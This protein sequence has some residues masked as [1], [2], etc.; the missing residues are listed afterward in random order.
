M[1][2]EVQRK[3][4]EKQRKLERIK[5]TRLKLEW[6]ATRRIWKGEWPIELF[7]EYEFARD[8][9]ELS[10]IRSHQAFDICRT[11]NECNE[12]KVVRDGKVTPLSSIIDG[13]GIQSLPFK[14]RH[15]LV[16]IFDKNR[17]LVVKRIPVTKK[18]E[19][20]RRQF[21]L[22]NNLL[23]WYIE[24][25]RE[26]VCESV[27]PKTIKYGCHRE[28]MRKPRL[29][30]DSCNGN[31]YPNAPDHFPEDLTWEVGPNGEVIKTIHASLEE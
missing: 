5:E 1:Q 13:R 18:L 12:T 23:N 28:C 7:R 27:V 26:P 25:K 15:E 17:D 16:L 20:Y 21:P 9:I 2:K 14:E 22:W 6:L 4:D 11:C 31:D 3:I 24:T 10:K 29:F 30:I 8:L 19:W